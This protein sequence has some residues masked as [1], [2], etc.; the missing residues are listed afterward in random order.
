MK[1]KS[2]FG[3]IIWQLKPRKEYHAVSNDGKKAIIISKVFE[4]KHGETI[5]IYQ[6]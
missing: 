6:H 4:C 3:G 1:T 2:F 5:A